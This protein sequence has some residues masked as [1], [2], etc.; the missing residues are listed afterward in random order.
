MCKKII[1]STIVA[2]IIGGGSLKAF[3]HVQSSQQ[4][5]S[6]ATV[7]SSE[8]G[9]VTIG[10]TTYAVPAGKSLQVQG[11][12]VTA[13]LESVQEEGKEPM[14]TVEVVEH[15]T[16]VT[17]DGKPATPSTDDYNPENDNDEKDEDEHDEAS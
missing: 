12:G 2:A 7:S 6:V 15:P 17:I 4:S 5:S 14:T 13:H 3:S 9:N 16:V 10:D 11:G 8:G 1:Q